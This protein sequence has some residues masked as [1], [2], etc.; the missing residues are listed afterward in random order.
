MFSGVERQTNGKIFVIFL[1]ALNGL[2]P[3]MN[4]SLYTTGRM[5]L[6]WWLWLL[7]LLLWLLLLLA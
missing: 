1:F 7:L 6:W 5:M 2:S 4:A 3:Y